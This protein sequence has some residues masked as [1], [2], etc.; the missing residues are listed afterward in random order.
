MALKNTESK[1]PFRGAFK[2][3]KPEVDTFSSETKCGLK[4]YRLHPG[5]SMIRKADHKLAGDMYKEPDTANALKWCGPILHAN[6]SGYWAFPAVD[7]DITYKGGKDWD[8]KEYRGYAATEQRI[9][10]GN[11][12]PE[13]KF[14]DTTRTRTAFSL[15]EPATFQLWTGCIFRTPPGWCLH[16]RNPINFPDAYARPFHIQEGIIESDWM[17]YDI[18]FN[19]KF[20]KIGEKVELRRDMWPPLAQIVPVRRTSYDGEWDLEDKILSIDDP[21]GLEVWNGWQDYNYR[22]W[23]EKDAKEP[24]T[25]HLTRKPTLAEMRE[26]GLIP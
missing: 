24:L 23:K 11:L 19:L 1:C 22:K 21:D 4:V 6:K 12:R 15:S 8:I 13:D 14:R 10:E 3:K 5:G 26:Q 9:I 2:G 7:M 16:V 20:H 18:W 17:N 25:Y